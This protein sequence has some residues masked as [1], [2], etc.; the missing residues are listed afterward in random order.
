MTCTRVRRVSIAL[1]T[2]AVL[3]AGACSTDQP[4]PES[5][6]TGGTQPSGSQLPPGDPT[7]A[8][9][10]EGIARDAMGQYQ[11]KSMIVR[12]TMDGTDVYTGA[13]G[14]SM[15]G[16]PATPDMHFR[17]GAFSYAYLGY[18]TAQLAAEGV[19]SLDDTID[20][21][22]PELPRADQVTVG[23]LP[24][25]TSGYSDY[26]Y[27]EEVGDVTYLDPFRQW[28]T[29]ELIQV[30][31]DGPEQFAP[32]TN[33]GYSHTNFAILGRVLE[34]A[35]G[36]DLRD[37][38][39]ERVLGPMGLT[40]TGDDDATPIIP[41][42]VQHSF[43][44]ERRSILEVPPGIPLY[45]D[46]TFWNPSWTGPTGAVQTTT[47]TDV[48][49]SMTLMGDGSLTS[50][51]AHEMQFEAPVMGSRDPTGQCSACR[52]LTEDFSYGM[53]MEI[54]RDWYV[55]NKEFVGSYV[56]AGYLPA[57]KLTIAVA[58]TMLPESFDADGTPPAVIR[59][60]FQDLAVA[61]G[62]AD[63]ISPLPPSGG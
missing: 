42:P 62:G 29:D 32:G 16:V 15:T 35:T 45:E 27:S 41:E 33:F 1:A 56:T 43:T 31:V 55:Q 3:F 11:L 10:V 7:L 37:L 51:E 58:V 14:E 5:S 22:V 20:A 38:M 25:S 19:F 46:S 49:T 18:I 36:T 24:H 8:A 30:G 34:E 44:S 50:P 54:H 28:T 12:V 17:N 39:Q 26:V 59:P 4:A 40:E 9:T 63:A 47:I 48:A 2:T 53:G 21:W 52:P 60:I 6:G 23:D 61:L 13:L 57:K